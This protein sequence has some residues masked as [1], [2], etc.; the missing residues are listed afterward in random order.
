VEE[1]LELL[2]DLVNLELKREQGCKPA[3][4]DRRR[5]RRKI[6][7]ARRVRFKWAM[8]CVV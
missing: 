6:L 4:E 7:V 2:V 5:E 3:L 1:G 8:V